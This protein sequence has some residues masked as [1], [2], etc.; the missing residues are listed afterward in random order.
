MGGGQG[1]RWPLRACPPGSLVPLGLVAVQVAGGAAAEKAEGGPSCTVFL[2]RQSHEY[3]CA[4]K[5][6]K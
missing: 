5:S 1:Q 6:F 4:F 2:E 3:S